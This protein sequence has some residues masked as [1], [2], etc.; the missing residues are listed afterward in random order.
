[1]TYKASPSDEDQYKGD[2]SS[3]D[4][5]TG[6]RGTFTDSN[7]TVPPWIPSRNILF[8]PDVNESLIGNQQCTNCLQTKIKYV[9]TPGKD[10][11]VQNM[12]CHIGY[13][14]DC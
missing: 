10:I 4:D 12:A 5:Q 6:L 11:T 14:W 8:S 3:Y 13:Y 7:V 2:E 9:I 1:M